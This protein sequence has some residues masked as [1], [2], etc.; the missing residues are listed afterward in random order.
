MLLHICI[1]IKKMIINTI[2]VIA[3]LYLAVC[4]VL[5]FFQ[6]K[7][8]FFP[9]KLQQ[10]FKFTFNQPFEELHFTC[11]DSAVLHGVLFK[12][13]LPKGL[14]FYLH[15][16]AGSLNSWGIL[17][18]AYTSLGYDVCMVDY[19]GYGKS[20][21][22]INSQQQLFADLQLVYDEMKKKY[23]EGKIIVLGYSLGSGFA[24]K[25]ASENKPKLLILQ[26][27][28]FSIT[29]MMRHNYPVIPTFILKYTIP[30]NK[31]IKNCAMPVILFHGDKDE[32][33]YYN[34]SIKLK[35]LFKNSDTLIT[36][37][38]QGHNGITDNIEYRAS[39]KEILANN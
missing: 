29:D 22:C 30:T 33:I 11:S 8:I 15:G 27:P 39:I 37:H 20:Q 23:D 17:A 25:I 21:G 14:V 16:N 36:L 13:A 35:K 26:A 28:Y 34:S 6:E 18:Q 9:E 5:Y 1:N 19:R 32:V 2:K 31:Y 7:L 24:T 12:A 38:G 3:V 4:V 10:N